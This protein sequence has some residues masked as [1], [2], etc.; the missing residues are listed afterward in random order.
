M[1]RET[2]GEVSG[3]MIWVKPDAL[4]PVTRSLNGFIA[5][6]TT[7]ETQQ[8]DKQ[9]L[10]HVFG[11]ERVNY[12]RF[13]EPQEPGDPPP[14]LCSEWWPTVADFAKSAGFTA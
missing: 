8:H 12:I 9:I 2:T 5:V 3:F 13:H 14:A 1:P 11:S 7:D 10:D 6:G 4:I